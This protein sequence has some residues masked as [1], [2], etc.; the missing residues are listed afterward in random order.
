MLRVLRSRQCADGS[1]CLALLYIPASCVQCC[2]RSDNVLD[3]PIT[4]LRGLLHIVIA[5]ASYVIIHLTNLDAGPDN[6]DPKRG[7]AGDAG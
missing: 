7:D 4:T 1:A 2:L 3:F 6:N 5:K